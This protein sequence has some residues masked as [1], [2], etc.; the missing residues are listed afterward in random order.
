MLLQSF[1]TLTKL[2]IASILSKLHILMTNNHYFTDLY[3]L[4][5]VY[6]QFLND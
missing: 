4:T 5:Y 1:T 2:K 3:N 6:R